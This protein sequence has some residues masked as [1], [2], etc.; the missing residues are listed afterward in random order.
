[1]DRRYYPDPRSRERLVSDDTDF[2]LPVLRL[3]NVKTDSL[4][5]GAGACGQIRV[6]GL[7]LA[8]ARLLKLSGSAAT[9]QD[10]AEHGKKTHWPR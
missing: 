9:L 1:M 3:E 7:G 2:L 6:N 4:G 8:S 10:T 5:P